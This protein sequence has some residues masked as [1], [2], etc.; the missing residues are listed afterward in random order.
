M[1]TSRKIV[2]LLSDLSTSWRR[3]V[4][5]RLGPAS[6]QEIRGWL[7]RIAA[8]RQGLLEFGRVSDGEFSGLARGLAHLNS[9]LADLQTQTESLNAVLQ[10]R[11]EDRAISSAYALY[12][13]SVD[14][15]HA[16]AGIA[17]SA[18]EQLTLV[19]S[20]L[21]KSCARQD[22]FERDHMFLRIV[23]LGIRIEVS[24]LPPDAQAVF[25]NVASAIAETGDRLR[26]CTA[27]AF[28]RIEAV[29]AESRAARE[30]L[31]T[32]EDALQLKARQ[33][34]DTLQRELV[35]LQTALAPC[36]DESR[37][38]AE[39]LAVVRPKTVGVIAALQ[40]Q[41]IVRQQLEHV[42]EGFLD[43]EQH[44][45]EPVA[46][47][48]SRGIEWAYVDHASRLQAAQLTASRTQIEHAGVTVVTGLESML[49]TSA[50]MV[51]RFAAME[52]TA[53]TALDNCQIAD[54]F[55][56][57]LAALSGVVESSQKAN[58][59]TDH[60]VE[61][62]G[63]VVRV[64]SEEINR[65]ELDVKIVALNAQIAAVHLPSAE[66]LSKLAQETSTISDRNAGLTR[67]LS[68]DL[69][70]SLAQLDNLK[71]EGAAFLAIVAKEK[72]DLEAALTVVIAKLA[73]LVRRVRSGAVD[74]RREFSPVHAEGRALL[75]ALR[76]PHQ[77][78]ERFAP[79][80]QLCAELGEVCPS[81]TGRD[82]T[83]AAAL[84]KIEQH[85]R[86]YTMEQ[87]EARHAAALQAAPL[88]APS[89]AAVS[90]GEIELFAP[91]SPD[92][93]ATPAVNAEESANPPPAAEKFGDGIELF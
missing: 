65:Y 69:Q 83:S 41:D 50:A 68:E 51:E 22:T 43:L 17:A 86:R 42:G 75:S 21:E 36:L 34:I 37:G 88:P 1:S 59:R 45:R 61:R 13:N 5:R 91:S 15:V 54:L 33:S 11:D 79:A 44:L 84:D 60:L 29:I 77:I 8:A 23:T 92:A 18:H 39:L 20:A 93:A 49:E 81:E 46:G 58:A 48:A 76:F 74:A 38:I 90:E 70:A 31:R 26:A 32:T 62:I 10:D 6:A 14:L 28:G 19:E 80:L 30:A 7:V 63:E 82:A 67:Q 78:E 87:E 89:R 85:R 3:A 55:A 73:R 66:A 25:L 47:G 71:R 2:R 35:G 16:N 24:R 27:T 53:A 4:G 12:K 64:F 40:H 9:R 57:E 56:K 72:A 52:N